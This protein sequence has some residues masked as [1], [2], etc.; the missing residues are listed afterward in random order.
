MAYR[1][2]FQKTGSGQSL[3]SRNTLIKT[4]KRFEV[5]TLN[6]KRLITTDRL[7]VIVLFNNGFNKFRNGR[8]EFRYDFALWS[9]MY[10]EYCFGGKTSTVM[11]V[12]T[13]KV[14]DVSKLQPNNSEE[15]RRR[16]RY[17]QRWSESSKIHRTRH[18]THVMMH[19]L[20]D[21]EVS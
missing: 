2:R 4:L 12:G 18:G 15:Y 10:L 7:E 9:R 6:H 17:V 5:F 3:H 16:K 21:C 11:N 20:L 13:A 1:Q 8:L 14:S 19:C